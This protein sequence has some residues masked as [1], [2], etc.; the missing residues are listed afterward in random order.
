[1]RF[2]QI[3][4]LDAKLVNLLGFGSSL[5]V[6]LAAFLALNEKTLSRAPVTLFSAA[7]AIYLLL[8]VASLYA[9]SP[10]EWEA[11][12]KLDEVWDYA[13]RYPPSALGWW[14]TESFKSCCKQVEDQVT[15]KLVAVRIG[16]P[17]VVSEA[18][19]LVVGLAVVALA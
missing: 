7:A 1:M 17:L 4:A 9:Y 13:D 6:I 12:P 19:L 11:G 15:P 18:I 3:D 14:A 16:V 5:L 8:A 10:R 2:A